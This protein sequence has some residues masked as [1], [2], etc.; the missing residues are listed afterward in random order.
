MAGTEGVVVARALTKLFGLP[1]LRSGFAV[2]TGGFREALVGAR[3]PWNVSAPALATGARCMRSRSFVADTRER[4]RTERARMRDRL[5]GRFG[6][7]PSEAPFLL[8]DVGDRAVGDVLGRARDRGL[9]L[10]DATTFRGLESHV[11][12]AVRLPAENDRLL[13]VLADV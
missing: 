6:V 1:G 5:S 9:A 11:R 13:E 7:H 4:I 10:R 12:V 8:L 3:R 2:A